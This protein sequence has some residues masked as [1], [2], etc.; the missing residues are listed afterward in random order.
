MRIR[1]GNTWLAAGGRQSPVD[2]SVNGQQVIEDAQFFGALAATYYGR[3]K[4]STELTFTVEREHGSLKDAEV[5]LL[6]HWADLPRSGDVVVECGIGDDTQSV[7]LKGAVLE[8]MPQGIYRGRSTRVTYT[9]RG[10]L[11]STDSIPAGGDVDEDV[12]RRGTVDIGSAATE[13]EVS[14]DNAMT[15]TPTV[16]ATVVTPE[17]G[18][19]IA[20]TIESGSV[21]TDGF[22]AKLSFP[23]PDSTYKL[24]YVAIL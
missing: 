2:L 4:R 23:T 1:I 17:G 3:G 13:V 11:I 16:V 8:S 5:F 19:I 18:D 9:L 20:C 15:G 7:A 21:S 14:F 24:S 12:V 10:G 22:T 6:T